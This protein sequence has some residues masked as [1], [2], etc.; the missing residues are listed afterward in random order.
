MPVISTKIHSNVQA[1]ISTLKLENSDLKNN[2]ETLS[3]ENEKLKETVNNQN[4]LIDTS[5]C[6]TDELYC[7][8]ENLLPEVIE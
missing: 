7:M 2:V 1:I 5:L 6:A 8:I 4:N 3:I